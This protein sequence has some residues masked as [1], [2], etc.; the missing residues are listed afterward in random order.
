MYPNS[1]QRPLRDRELS[2]FEFFLVSL[3]GVHEDKHRAYWAGGPIDGG[4]EGLHLQKALLEVS[5]DHFTT[6][7]RSSYY[8]RGCD[9]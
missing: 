8:R 2:A 1:V 7:S 4:D 9:Q 3:L 6:N 5:Q